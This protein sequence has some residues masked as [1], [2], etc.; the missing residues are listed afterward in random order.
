MVP[1][2]SGWFREYQWF[3]YQLAVP[4]RSDPNDSLGKEP[5]GLERNPYWRT[6]WNKENN[7]SQRDPFPRESYGS[8]ELPD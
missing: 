5:F 8:G 2:G 3:D 4:I 1:D 7:L 6:I